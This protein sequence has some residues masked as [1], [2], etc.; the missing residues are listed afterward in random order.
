MLFADRT[1]CHRF[2]ANQF[3]V[4]LAAAYVLVSHLLR[5]GL[6]GTEHA[7]ATVQT[8]RLKLIKVGGMGAEVGT[9]LGGADVG[10]LSVDRSV[11]VGGPSAIG[12][13]LRRE[14]VAGREIECGAP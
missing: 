7:T 10:R 14:F 5:V 3:R 13:S 6:A 4:L 8:I 12:T 2:V 1:S 9:S 11:R